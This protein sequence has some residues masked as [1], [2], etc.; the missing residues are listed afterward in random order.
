MREISPFSVMNIEFKY[1]YDMKIFTVI[2]YILD[3][4]NYAVSLCL[5]DKKKRSW[6][7][8]WGDGSEG[9]KYQ[10]RDEGIEASMN[11]ISFYN[12]VLQS[13]CDA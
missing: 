7:H 10:H 2:M 1:F 6:R 9:G 5:E 8:E 4:G 13:K 3:K 12:F 11:V